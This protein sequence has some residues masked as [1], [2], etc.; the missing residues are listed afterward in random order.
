MENLTDEKQIRNVIQ[1]YNKAYEDKDI[2]KVMSFFSEDTKRIRLY[3]VDEKTA[4]GKNAVR[5]TFVEEFDRVNIADSTCDIDAPMIS[6]D[7]A[8]GIYKWRMDFTDLQN[9]G[10]KVVATGK[11]IVKLKK[12]DGIWKI[13]ELEETIDSWDQQE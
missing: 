10:V 12:A 1:G 7:A 6:G 5:A 8:S 13:T 4:I 3:K 2:G 11:G 9:N